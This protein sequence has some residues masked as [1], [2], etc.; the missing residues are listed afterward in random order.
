MNRIL[1]LAGLA[2]AVALTGGCSQKGSAQT[3]VEAAED[4]LMAVHEEAQKYI[5]GQ[6]AELKAELD[7]ARAY[8]NEEQYL[9]A[10][11]EVKDIPAKARALAAAATA[12][13]EALAAEIAVEWTRLRD[14]LPGRLAGLEGRLEELGKARRLPDGLTREALPRITAGAGIARAAWD[15]AAAAYEAGNLEGAVARAMESDNLAA[16]LMAELGMTPAPAAD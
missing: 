3:A 16:E 5:P 15:E 7:A 8:V 13:R 2:L 14:E 1:A 11:D 10:I 12:A 4:A 9:R 6:Y